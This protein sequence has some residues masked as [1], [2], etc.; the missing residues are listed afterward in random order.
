MAPYRTWLQADAVAQVLAGQRHGRH[1]ALACVCW[2]CHRRVPLGMG[3][4]KVLDS[5][6]HLF[7]RIFLEEVTGLC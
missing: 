3:R 2:D 5:L 6:E 1:A 7:W 4:E